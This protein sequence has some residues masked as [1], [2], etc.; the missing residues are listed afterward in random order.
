M[1]RSLGILFGFCTLVLTPTL[2]ADESFY[3]VNQKPGTNHLTLEM[4]VGDSSFSGGSS[5]LQSLGFEYRRALDKQKSVWLETRMMGRRFSTSAQ[6]GSSGVGLS[7]VHLGYKD[8]QIYDLVTFIF[9]SQVSLS[10]GAAQDPRLG[11]VEGSN[12]FTGTQSLAGF[13]GFE[14]YSEALAVGGQV[15]LR[16]Y[17]DIRAV[18]G[19][20][21]VTVTNRN[22]LIPRFSGFIEV[23]VSRSVDIGFEAALARP[24][25]ALDKYIL[26][27]VGN[28]YEA[29]FYG[30]WD[31]DSSTKAIIELAAK[32]RK[33]PLSEESVDIGVG[34]RRSL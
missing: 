12:S 31:Y 1:G 6:G 18:D 29:G 15:E 17:S 32:S 4:G 20:D 30:H 26:G 9:G 24:D 11:Q 33:Y 14:S 34:L 21:V 3:L 23:P 13:L 5:Q 8:G 10:P 22:R 28:Q 27:G 25:L 16:A 7:D 19:E 2:F